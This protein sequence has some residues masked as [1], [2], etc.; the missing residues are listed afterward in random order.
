MGIEKDVFGSGEKQP[1]VAP[2]EG[3][4]LEQAQKAEGRLRL[5]QAERTMEEVNEGVKKLLSEGYNLD[6][7]LES[8]KREVESGGN[9]KENLH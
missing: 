5:E 7:V 1:T 3:L 9:G 2:G 6:E 8:I 4:S